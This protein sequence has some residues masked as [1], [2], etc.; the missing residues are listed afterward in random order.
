M[1]GE[2]PPQKQP[3]NCSKATSFNS[4]RT[5][6]FTAPT[7]RGND[8]E[9]VGNWGIATLKSL[10]ARGAEQRETWGHPHP[11]IPQGRGCGGDVPPAARPGASLVCTHASPKRLRGP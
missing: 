2:C 5:P 9:A 7:K 4:V 8:A 3:G 1:E 11:N 6:S 10:L